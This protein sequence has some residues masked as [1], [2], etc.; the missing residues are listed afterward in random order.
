[1]HLHA[2]GCFLK[3]LF[4]LRRTASNNEER[5][6]L[7]SACQFLARITAMAVGQSDMMF[8]FWSQVYTHLEYGITNSSML[9]RW[10]CTAAEPHVKLS[11]EEVRSQL[12]FG[13]TGDMMLRVWQHHA[14]TCIGR[15]EFQAVCTRFL[16]HMSV[17]GL[18][19]WCDVSCELQA[20]A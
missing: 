7:H 20:Q 9:E 1:M 16:C 19:Q 10:V 4:V 18:F 12:M 3:D 2:C 6:A 17:H 14:P 13:R 8:N 5:Q 15:A 11:A